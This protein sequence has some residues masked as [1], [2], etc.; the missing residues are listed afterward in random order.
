MNNTT[1]FM[2][3]TIDLGGSYELQTM[4][5]YIYDAA[6]STD[7]TKKA[8][9]GK[10]LLIQVYSDG[11]WHD[12]VVCANNSELTQHLVIEDGLSNDYL[13]FDLEGV[14][15][16]KLRIYISGAESTDG[17]T[18]QEIECSAK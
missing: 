6:K 9:V 16:E 13:Q 12:V 8:S 5:F 2:D 3:A 11:S 4:K 18:F 7:S 17:I 10:D 1:V 14:K 15:A